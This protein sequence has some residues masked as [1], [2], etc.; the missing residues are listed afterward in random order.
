MALLPPLLFVLSL[1]FVLFYFFSHN[2]VDFVVCVSAIGGSPAGSLK[3]QAAHANMGKKMK[4]SYLPVACLSSC[5]SMNVNV[6]KLEERGSVV[7]VLLWI[8]PS[9]A[10]PCISTPASVPLTPGQHLGTG[11]ESLALTSALPL[12]SCVTLEVINLHGLR[13]SCCKTGG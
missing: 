7:H 9:I 4:G 8:F 10:L 6:W 2:E 11:L 13:S 12:A 5:A 1:H 3:H